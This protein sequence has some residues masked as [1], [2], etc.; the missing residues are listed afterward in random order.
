MSEAVAMSGL[1]LRA[2]LSQQCEAE[3]GQAAWARKHRVPASQV[4]EALNGKRDVSR[5][6]ILAMGLMPVTRY[7]LVRRAA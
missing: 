5:G 6:I 4:C 3:G 2:M 1:Q 7:V